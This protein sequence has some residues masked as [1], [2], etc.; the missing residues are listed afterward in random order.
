MTLARSGRRR[1]AVRRLRAGRLVFAMVDLR[2]PD[3]NGLASRA[4]PAARARL[5]AG[6][7]VTIP[8]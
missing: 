1:V 4:A 7:S 6:P 8:A 2:M 5:N 3:V